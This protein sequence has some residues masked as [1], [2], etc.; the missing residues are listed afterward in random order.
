MR[1]PF[2]V[3]PRF[4]SGSVGLDLIKNSQMLRKH[5]ASHEEEMVAQEFIDAPDNEFT[6]GLSFNRDGKLLQ[7][8]ILKR[9]LKKGFTQFAAVEQQEG[10]ELRI[11]EIASVL[12]GRGSYNIQGKLVDGDFVVFEINPRFSGTTAFRAV[13]GI[14]E[15]DIYIQH[16]LT[17]RVPSDIKIRSLYMMRYLNEC[18]VDPEAIEDLQKR[19]CLEAPKGFKVDYF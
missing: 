15:P 4:G 7:T 19:G 14:N 10:V 9:S 17:G 12:E 1:Y 16:C 3:K 11:R 8:I 2:I 6:C 5:F 13:L 18:Y